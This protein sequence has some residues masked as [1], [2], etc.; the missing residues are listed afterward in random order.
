[1]D[2]RWL[3]D[4]IDPA[5]HVEAEAAAIVESLEALAQ[6]L[7]L[8][9]RTVQRSDDH[10]GVF[11]AIHDAD[12]DVVAVDRATNLAADAEVQVVAH[13]VAPM[14]STCWNGDLG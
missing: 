7:D 8:G 12:Q 3:E 1:M 4:L 11:G 14:I 2:V 9:S 13:D 5:M 10:H 6:P